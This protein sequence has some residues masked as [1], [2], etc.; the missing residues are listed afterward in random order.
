M[1]A[2][3]GEAAVGA[4]D[5]AVLVRAAVSHPMGWSSKPALARAWKLHPKPA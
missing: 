5:V 4:V 2:D 3:P 1:S